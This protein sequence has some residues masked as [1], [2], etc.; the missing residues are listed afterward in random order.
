MPQLSLMGKSQR[1]KGK[2]G[3]RLVSGFLTDSGWPPRRSVQFCGRDPAAVA[4][5][6]VEGFP[7]LAIEVKFRQAW[8]VDNW[9]R[10]QADECKD[11]QLPILFCKKDNEPL[12]VSLYADDFIK[13][14]RGDFA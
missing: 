10:R 9:L 1:N 8:S 2:R 14:W 6:V 5:L 12:V 3:E 4:D 7:Q 13:F 11:G